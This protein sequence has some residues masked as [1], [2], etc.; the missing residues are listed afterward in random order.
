MQQ[1]PTG[2]TTD[3]SDL[4]EFGDA[5][6]WYELVGPLHHAEDNTPGNVRM[7]FYS[8]QKYISSMNRVH[9]GMIASFFD[10][11][12]FT[13][14]Y[15]MWQSP[16]ATVSLNINYVSACPPGIWVEGHGKTVH[17]G[18]SMAFTE[19]EIVADNK[20]IAH[21]TGTFRKLGG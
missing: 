3:G 8:N 19:G 1:P 10:Y 12:L 5:G 20:I 14:A 6:S 16:L 21:A 9:G 17:S 4:E 18:K 11:L 13:A 15:S 7:G 2:F